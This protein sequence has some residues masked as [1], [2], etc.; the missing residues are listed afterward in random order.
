MQ[1]LTATD[2]FRVIDNQSVNRE[3]GIALIE[4]YATSKV[5]EAANAMRKDFGI[6][7]DA[8]IEA[9]IERVNDSLNT[10]FKLAL[11]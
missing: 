4:A 3:R 9:A 2:I 11:P 7:Y 5:N 10:F 1:T 8:E 6:T